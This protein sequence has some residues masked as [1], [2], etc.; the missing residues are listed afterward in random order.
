[1]KAVVSSSTILASL[2]V[3]QS[4]LQRFPSPTHP[5]TANL[6][7]VDLMLSL[8]KSIRRWEC[9][10]WLQNAF[11]SELLK[12]MNK[13]D[14]IAL[15]ASAD[16]W[17]ND[18]DNTCAVYEG[19]LCVQIIPVNTCCLVGR[20]MYIL[21]GIEFLSSFTFFSIFFLPFNILSNMNVH[22]SRL[23]I[24]EYI[25]CNYL[26]CVPTPEKFMWILFLFLLACQL[27][28]AAHM[29]LSE[30]WSKLRNVSNGL[31][32][33]ASSGRMSKMITAQ[34]FQIAKRSKVWRNNSNWN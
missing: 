26:I 5:E 31:E 27:L 25:K 18:H 12:K 7:S 11:A 4:S 8:N 34:T 19:V 22:C 9:P 2:P 33:G 1:M 28:T 17:N 15:T 13:L 6:H 24:K 10:T 3:R 21:K 29:L 30:T 32:N 16:I 14:L 20:E 23:N